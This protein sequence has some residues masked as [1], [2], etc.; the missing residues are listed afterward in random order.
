MQYIAF[1]FGFFNLAE[2]VWDASMLL[3]VSVICPFL[4]PTSIPLR[5]CDICDLSLETWIS[6]FSL[7]NMELQPKPIKMWDIVLER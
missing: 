2:A 5:I 6:L 1:V 3:F 7:E 4:L